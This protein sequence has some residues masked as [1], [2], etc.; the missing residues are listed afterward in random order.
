MELPY[1]LDVS[2]KSAERL[3]RRAIFAVGWMDP[4]SVPDD[5]VTLAPYVH[6][7]WRWIEAVGEAGFA[8]MRAARLLMRRRATRVSAEAF[9]RLGATYVTFEVPGEPGVRYALSED[10]SAQARDVR[11]DEL[12]VWELDTARLTAK[13]R[14]ELGATAA[15]RPLP[16]VVDLGWVEIGGVRIRFFYAMRGAGESLAARVLAACT[17]G[18]VPVVLVPAGRRVG[19]GLRQVELPVSEQLGAAGIARV[20]ARVAEDLELDGLEAWRTTD[21]VVV[22]DRANQRVWIHGVLMTALAARSYK[23]IECLA[24]HAGEIVTPKDLATHIQGKY[25]NLDEVV[26]KVRPD[27]LR[28]VERSFRAAGKAVPKDVLARLAVFEAKRGYRLA[29]TAHVV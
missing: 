27:L 12:V 16:G 5:A 19:E 4:G 14:E 7:E 29:L 8:A 15:D 2:E 13:M 22:V 20:L 18:V 23:M 9:R 1:R 17:K 6:P 26:R 25:G 21:A 24:M 3:V 11:D 28:R 10:R